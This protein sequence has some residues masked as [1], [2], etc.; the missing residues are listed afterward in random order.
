LA[1]APP[2]LVLDEPTSALDVVTELRLLGRLRN[3]REGTTTLLLTVSAP[4][5][6]LCD[7]VALVEGGRVVREESHE[8]L[9][10]DARYR[11]LVAPDAEVTSA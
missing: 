1:A 9:M 7:R 2:V 3:A 8:Q 4:A 10:H 6:A 5:L 11:A